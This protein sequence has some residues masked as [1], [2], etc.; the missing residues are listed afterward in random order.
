MQQV[1]WVVQFKDG[2]HVEEISANG[3][4]TVFSG[5]FLA[6]KKDFAFI[7]LKDLANKLQYSIDLTTGELILNGQ[8]FSPAKE[9]EGR[10]Y[11]VTNLGIDYALGAIQYKVSKPMNMGQSNQ[12]EPASF[13]I[14]Y[15]ANLPKD[16]LKHER[17]EGV[18]SYDVVQVLLTVDADTLRPC[19]SMTF[20]AKIVYPDGKQV[21]I[22]M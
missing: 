21:M 14:G 18:I 1:I 3:K 19:M 8:A 20:L 11:K 2:S 10:S 13:N 5:D 15:K 17:G 22:K 9:L 12:A 6:R 4:E 16:F 7:G